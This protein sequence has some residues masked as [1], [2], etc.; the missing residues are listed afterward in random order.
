MS[1]FMVSKEH[2]DALVATALHGPRDN[3][4]PGGY[5]QG[6]WFAPYFGD[7]PTAQQLTIQNASE[8]GDMLVKEN[9][10]SIH[11]RY[12]DT[13]N[14]PENTPGPCEA[15]W[16]V[17]YVFPPQTKA[18]SI[19]QCCKALACYEY[20]SCE[21]PEWRNST[22]REFCNALRDSLVTCLPGYEDA[23]WELCEV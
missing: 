9:L 6:R 8:L 21:H 22:A 20:Q 15:Y 1:A 18:L 16:M 4:K 7:E 10:S 17:D 12:P 11:Y 13:I 23:R 2:I 3:S 5:G 19:V 14:N